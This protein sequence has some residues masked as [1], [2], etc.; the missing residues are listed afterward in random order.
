MGACRTGLL[1]SGPLEEQALN[2]LGGEE[3]EAEHPWN[4]L[5]AGDL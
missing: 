4:V 2:L 1:D 3:E 5:C